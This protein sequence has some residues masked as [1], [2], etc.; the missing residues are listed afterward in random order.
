MIGH[1]HR[2]RRIVRAA[3]TYFKAVG[4][5]AASPRD[6]T[7]P[8]VL[9]PRS[10]LTITDAICSSGGSPRALS[11]AVVSSTP[12]F[13]AEC[14]AR[15]ACSGFYERRV[16]LTKVLDTTEPF[17]HSALYASPPGHRTPVRASPFGGAVSGA[18]AAMDLSEL[19]ASSTPRYPGILAL[20]A[21]RYWPL[22]S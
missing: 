21:S 1:P 13:R 14:L 20:L 4:R 10:R 5:G 19:V 2:L 15:T 12:L 3:P 8:Y 16:T 17:R 7:V 9:S 22:V 11:A 6:L 18:I